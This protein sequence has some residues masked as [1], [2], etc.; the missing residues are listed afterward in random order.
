MSTDTAPAGGVFAHAPPA[1]V[2]VLGGGFGG[3]ETAFGSSVAWR[4]GKKLLGMSVPW[5][6]GSG[7]PFH[8]GLFWRGMDVGA[9]WTSG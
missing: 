2:V 6:F 4:A 9:A 3:L 5:R 1:Q 8:A 7:R